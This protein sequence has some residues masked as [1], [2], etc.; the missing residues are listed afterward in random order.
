[1]DFRCSRPSP[2]AVTRRRCRSIRDKNFYDSARVRGESGRVIR[3]LTAF[4]ERFEVSKRIFHEG[5]GG[6]VTT[7]SSTRPRATSRVHRRASFVL[8]SDQSRAQ[9]QAELGER[10]ATRKAARVTQKFFPTDVDLHKVFPPCTS[11]R[12]ESKGIINRRFRRN[13]RAVTESGDN[14]VRRA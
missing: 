2:S 14:F 7:Q 12:V 4:S 6:D 13:P 3:P 5:I 11:L 8:E 10:L 1:M 9:S